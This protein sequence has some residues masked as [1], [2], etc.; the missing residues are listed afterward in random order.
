MY[1][2]DTLD[3]SLSSVDSKSRTASEQSEHSELSKSRLSFSKKA[4]ASA[5]E[6][7]MTENER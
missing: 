1:I 7:A 5:R 6:G 4:S 3:G 2:N